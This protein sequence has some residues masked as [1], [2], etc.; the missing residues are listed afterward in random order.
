MYLLKIL[1]FMPTVFYKNTIFRRFAN[2][3][4][5]KFGGIS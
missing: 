5:A 1:C 4:Q 3:F 2:P